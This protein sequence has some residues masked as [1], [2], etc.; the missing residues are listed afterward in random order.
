MLEPVQR[1]HGAEHLGLNAVGCEQ[2]DIQTLSGR[3]LV[4]ATSTVATGPTFANATAATTA[5]TTVAGRV[6]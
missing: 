3:A 5:A 2:R 4:L 6:E 1:S